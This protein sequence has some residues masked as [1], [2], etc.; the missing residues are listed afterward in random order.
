MRRGSRSHRRGARSP[1]ARPAGCGSA[2]SDG[3]RPEPALSPASPGRAAMSSSH[4]TSRMDRRR[5]TSSLSGGPARPASLSRSPAA[6]LRSTPVGA[7]SFLPC[8]AVVSGRESF[9]RR[10]PS[11]DTGGAAGRPRRIDGRHARRSLSAARDFR[12]TDARTPRMKRSEFLLAGAAA[13]L[14]LRRPSATLALVTADTESRVA[15]VD[16]DLVSCAR[17]SRPARGRA[18]SNAWGRRRSSLTP[19]S[20]R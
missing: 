15:V 8:G 16:L 17:T 4:S 5:F 3:C 6:S 11:V 1:W 13:T 20:A 9:P 14:A 2:A 12:A 7:I 10:R 18:A 19:C